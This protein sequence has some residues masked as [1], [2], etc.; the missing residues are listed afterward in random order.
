[1]AFDKTSFDGRS[2]RAG[3]DGGELAGWNRV[4]ASHT[5]HQ[6]TMYYPMRVIRTPRYK[7][8]HNL[9]HE[10]TFPLARDLGESSTWISA[11]LAPGRDT[12]A[13]APTGTP[14]VEREQRMFGQRT[15]AA[16]LHR[17][18]YE[19]YDLQR[20]PDE[21]KNLADDPAHE[22]LKRQ[23]MAEL[24]AFQLRTKDPWGNP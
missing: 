24:T 16:F 2:F 5:F 8:I 13:K 18:E 4:F 17:P 20:D 11:V 22:A 9:A 1:V 14:N 6:I 10:L 3:L 7:L 12:E 19:L 15:V 21:V 23:L